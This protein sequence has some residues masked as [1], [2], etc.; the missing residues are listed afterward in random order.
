MPNGITF[1]LGSDGCFAS[2][3][4]PAISYHANESLVFSVFAIFYGPR[5]L[6]DAVAGAADKSGF[7]P[8]IAIA[9]A[10]LERWDAAVEAM[11]LFAIDA[12]A[13]LGGVAGIFG[14][15]GPEGIRNPIT[16]LPENGYSG[17][18]TTNAKL[19]QQFA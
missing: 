18:I 10:A 3:S 14:A 4:G 19:N 2:V 16:L 1:L 8:A 11:A 7:V 17:N 5:S 9:A 13:A 6:G 15:L 12:G